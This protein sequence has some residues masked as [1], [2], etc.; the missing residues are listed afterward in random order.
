MGFFGLCGSSF[1]GCVPC[2]LD[3][4]SAQCIVYF[5]CL[6]YFLS[7]PSV[8]YLPESNS[9]NSLKNW[10]FMERLF[11]REWLI[12]GLSIG[13]VLTVIAVALYTHYFVI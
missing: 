9:R 11:L 3:G 6:R 10:V 1:G 8:K 2:G 13:F 4:H 7:D 5:S 12:L